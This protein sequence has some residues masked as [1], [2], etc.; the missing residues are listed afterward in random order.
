M[1][2]DTVGPASI[3]LELLLVALYCSNNLCCRWE[4]LL[5]VVAE[6]LQVTLANMWMVS[7]LSRM[8]FMAQVHSMIPWLL[9]NPTLDP[10]LS[11]KIWPQ[12]ESRTEPQIVLGGILSF[13]E[14]GEDNNLTGLGAR[15]GGLSRNNHKVEINEAVKNRMSAGVQIPED[16]NII[17]NGRLK[18]MMSKSTN[19]GEHSR[20]HSTTWTGQW[21]SE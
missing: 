4:V 16:A 2:P 14:T 19:K 8:E 7:C 3:A 10:Q 1:I 6:G 5:N 12:E 13:M 9:G 15:R 18:G 17:E 11:I 21:S 20:T